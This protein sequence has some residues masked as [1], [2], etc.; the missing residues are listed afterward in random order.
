MV[1]KPVSIRKN[2]ETVL[3]LKHCSKIRQHVKFKPD[4]TNRTGFMTKNNRSVRRRK[5]FLHPFLA[6][7][8]KITTLDPKKNSTCGFH[9]RIEEGYMYL[10]DKKNPVFEW[11]GSWTIWTLKIALSTTATI[12]PRQSQSSDTAASAWYIS[13]ESLKSLLSG[14]EIWFFENVLGA[15][16]LLETFYDMKQ[17]FG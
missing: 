10:E 5:E 4:R 16:L 8:K 3:V 6:N 2:L 11:P 15:E 12:L 7:F 1:I 13:F 14:D 17:Y 9:L